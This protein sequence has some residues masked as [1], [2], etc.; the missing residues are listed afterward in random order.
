MGGSWWWPFGGKEEPKMSASSRV[1]CYD[2]RDEYFACLEASG[3]DKSKCS[4]LQKKFQNN[5]HPAWVKYFEQQRE[6]LKMQGKPW[7]SPN[8]EGKNGS[9]APQRA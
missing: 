9:R 4:A 1:T 8:M 2:N 3:D 5:C 6:K 7:T